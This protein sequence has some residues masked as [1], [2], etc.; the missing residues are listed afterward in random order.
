MALNKKDYD[1]GYA[2][3]VAHIKDML[4][5]SGDLNTSP[6]GNGS[7]S[8]DGMDMDLDGTPAGD[9]MKKNVQN[10][11]DSSSSGSGGRGSG[12][13]G[14]VSPED[15]AGGFGQ[16][17]PKTPG[18]Y[19]SSNEGNELAKKEGYNPGSADDANSKTWKEAALN[20]ANNSKPG[21]KAGS[22]LSK[23]LDIYKTTTDW[24]KAFKKI[25]G[26]SLNFQDKRSAYANKNALAT[27]DMILRTEKD[28][29]DVVDYMCIFTDASGSVTDDMLRY[30]LS[31]IY[32]IAYSMK[33]VQLVVGQF[34]T[35]ITDVQIFR[36]SKEFK[37][38]T[39]NAKVK[40]RGGTECKCIWDFM[41]NDKRLKGACQLVIIM[42][43]GELSQYKRDSKTMNNLC[44]VILNN[45]RWNVEYK[46]ART[47]CIHLDSRNIK[48]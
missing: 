1:E 44:W 11:D 32:N 46:D 40:G 30:M 28:K 6:Q 41:R 5:G 4:H 39:K 2:A 42:T 16:Y 3:A 43:D 21:S 36:S 10:N 22:L 35:K 33:P 27:R 23:I 34:D 26:R 20:A 37:N 45:N 14:E 18:G 7:S 38:Y 47:T 31:E 25:I 15:M 9:A 19:M 48:K 17:T 12:N 24:K 8:D 29:Y 13:Q